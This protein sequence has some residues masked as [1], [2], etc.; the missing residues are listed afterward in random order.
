MADENGRTPSKK[1]VT[2]F[3]LTAH[4]VLCPKVMG[5]AM[6]F[7][8]LGGKCV[9]W[10]TLD[11]LFFIDEH[12]LGTIM[13]M[14]VLLC[15][16]HM[17]KS[18]TLNLPL[19]REFCITLDAFEGSY[20]TSRMSHWSTPNKVHF[21]STLSPFGYNDAHCTNHDI[22]HFLNCIVLDILF[23]LSDKISLM[24]NTYVC[25]ENRRYQSGGK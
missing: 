14:P 9:L 8:F 15:L 25:G 4:R 10:K 1:K 16:L 6:M 12:P 13:W 18:W 7:L 2:F 19:S 24:R 3:S 22:K 23:T 17:A 5:M 11:F 20:V 21:S